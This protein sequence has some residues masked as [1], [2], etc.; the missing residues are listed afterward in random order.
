K[1]FHARPARYKV[2]PPGLY[3]HLL[4]RTL[5]PMTEPN[6]DPETAIAFQGEPGAYSHLACL[7]AR[8]ALVPMPCKTFEDAFAAVE[9]GRARLGFIPVENSVAGR[10]ADVHHILPNAKLSVIGEHFFRVN[11][12]LLAVKGATLESIRVVRSHVHALGQC[13]NFLR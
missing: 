12:H 11:H 6:F 5:D 8:P 4:R 1:G 3:S 7:E 13:R 2:A 9:E 10:V